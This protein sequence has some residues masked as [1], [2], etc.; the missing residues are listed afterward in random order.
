[1]NFLKLLPLIFQALALIEPIRL[2]IRNGASVFDVLKEKGPTLIDFIQSI[3]KSIFP[4]LT[5]PEAQT[6]AG[7]LVAFDPQ[8]VMTIQT[9]LNRLG[10]AEPALVVDGAYGAK[11]KAAVLKF[12]QKFGLEPDTWAGQVTQAALASEVAKLP[13]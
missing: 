6:Q 9:S 13:M 12:Q 10:I 3:G 7:A 1:M 8:T 5:T 11:T 2:A 4:E